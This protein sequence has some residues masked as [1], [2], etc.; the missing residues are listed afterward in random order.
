MSEK[1]NLNSKVAYYLQMKEILQ[2]KIERGD[3][4]PGDRL[5]SEVEFCRMYNVSRSVVRQTLMELEYEGLI[6]KQRPKGTFVAEPKMILAI[7][8]LRGGF[9]ESLTR[10]GLNVDNRVLTNEVLLASNRLASNFNNVEVGEELIHVERVRYVNGSP[11]VLSNT[12]IPLNLCPRL[13]EADFSQS[14]FGALKELG[15][16]EM[17]RGE[18]NFEAVGATEKESEIFNLPVGTPMLLHRAKTFDQ[19]NNQIE[20]ALSVFRGDQSRVE[21]V[22]NRENKV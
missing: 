15:G 8:Y 4:K 6:I 21:G 18:I 16:I 3:Y 5:P 14:I 13:K 10:Q 2:A 19:Q 12:Y 1:I 9:G 7:N 11:L 22:I 17:E 20:Y